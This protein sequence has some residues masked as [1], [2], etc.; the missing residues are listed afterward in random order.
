MKN[1]VYRTESLARLLKAK[2]PFL[3]LERQFGPPFDYPQKMLETVRKQLP[4][5]RAVYRLECQTR[6][7]Q[8]NGADIVVLR[9]PARNALFAEVTR[10]ADERNLASGVIYFGVDDAV[11]P[12]NRVSPRL[13]IPFE[14]VDVQVDG[15][16][17]P[18]T[19]E[20]LASLT[21]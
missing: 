15:R 8:P 16:W 20:I 7:P 1:Y 2:E 21:A 14:K 19:R 4:A 13:A 11:S 3:R 10:I 6:A 12:T 9:I 18:L 17:L 5:S